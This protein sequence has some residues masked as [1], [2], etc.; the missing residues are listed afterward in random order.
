MNMP[1]QQVRDRILGNHNS[2][3]TFELLP[4]LR[5]TLD[6]SVQEQGLVGR[7]IDGAARVLS[8]PIRYLARND[9]E[10]ITA[11][12][13]YGVLQNLVL[14]LGAVALS[15]SVGYGVAAC[16]GITTVSVLQMYGVFTNE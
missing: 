12:L 8:L 15:P 3:S 5:P 7:S 6:D 9:P 13:S 11:V 4:N 16:W 2:Q 1:V 10:P 14:G